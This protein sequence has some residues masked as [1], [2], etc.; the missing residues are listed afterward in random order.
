MVNFNENADVSKSKRAN[1]VSV[2][3]SKPLKYNFS[4]LFYRGT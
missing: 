4:K 2:H 1:D 3:I